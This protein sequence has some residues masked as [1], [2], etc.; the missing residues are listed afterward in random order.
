MSEEKFAESLHLAQLGMHNLLDGSGVEH[1]SQLTQFSEALLEYH[2]NCI[3]LLQ[4]LSEK[5]YEKTNEASAK[6]KPVFRPK[7]LEDLGIERVHGDYNMG[8]GVLGSSRP[9]TATPTSNNRYKPDH[10]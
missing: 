7:T 1:I 10:V 4:P 2:R 3:E 8:G 5:L 6:A 9:Q